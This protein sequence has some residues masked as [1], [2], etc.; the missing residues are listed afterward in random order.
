MTNKKVDE[1]KDD[2]DDYNLEP[3]EIHATTARHDDWLHRGCLLADL[4]WLAYMMRVQR[5]RKPTQADA[6]YSQ[7]FFASTRITRCQ[8]FTA[9]RY[10][11]RVSLP[12]LGWWGRYVQPWKRTAENHMRDT[13]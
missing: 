4:P 6:D 13:S 11:T 12:F 9:K 1:N 8:F 2:N 7:P 5:V 3:A 10:C